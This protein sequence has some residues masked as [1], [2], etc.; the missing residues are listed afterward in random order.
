MDTL[1]IIFTVVIVVALILVG[2]YILGNKL[3]KKQSESQAL[4]Q[5]NKQIVSGMVIDKKKMKLTDSNMPKQVIDGVPW[6]LKMRKFP[7]AK[8]KVGPQF[9]TLI[10][11][12]SVYENLPL[13]RMIKL[14]V[15]GA[16]I[17]G[18]S[19][20][21]KGEKVVERPHKLT[22]RE[23]L[24]NRLN[25]ISNKVDKK[26][27]ADAKSN[28]EAEKKSQELRQKLQAQKAQKKNAK[29]KK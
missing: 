12:G 7:M 13:K 26:K 9:L 3:Q 8:V 25:G 14:E 20:A 5:Q 27:A 21:K 19:T 10:C 16:Y 22:F 28:A 29:G 11:D 18:F 6:Y 15:A 4:I 23:K 24:Q 1:G 2:L 17:T